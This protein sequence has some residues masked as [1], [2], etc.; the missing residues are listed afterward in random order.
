MKEWRKILVS[1][2][3]TI[4]ETI[5]KIDSNSLQIA[6]V[7]DEQLNLLG[8]VTDGDIRRALLKG[9]P[10]QTTVNEI[11]NTH[12]VT[13]QPNEETRQ[14]LK[15]MEANRLR[16]LPV[17]D[18][19]GS[20]KGVE[21]LESFIHPPRLDCWVVLMVGGLGKRLGSLTKDCPKPLLKVGNKP[22]LETILEKLGEC[23]FHQFYFVVNYKAEM[24]Q[25]YFGDGSHWGLEIRYIH[26][27]KRMGTAGGLKL[28]PEKLPQPILVMN[29]DLLTTLNFRQLLQF[30]TEMHVKATMCVR[31]YEI[32]V[33]YGVVK[34]ENQRLAN[35]VEKP[36]HQ[37]FVSAGIYVLEPDAL[38]YI[39]DNSYFDMPNLFQKLIAENSDI[40]A[41][42]LREYWV[43]IGKLDDF[44]R[45]NVE[46][47]EVFE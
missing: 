40:A 19:Q 31:Q 44:H 15:I 38:E 29:G 34:V 21:L 27:Q 36:I 12:P 26:E 25:A 3:A 37:F 20:L 33:P 16:H 43:D 30:H 9:V 17:V 14:I 5:E 47:N 7:I 8:T 35:I 4:R 32:E 11:M 41:F 42:P 22:I 13:I 18:E 24:I 10:L 6:L 46:Y 2:S 39:P 28:I 23:G 45:A 1:P